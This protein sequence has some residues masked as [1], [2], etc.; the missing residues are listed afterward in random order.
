MGWQNAS[1]FF[2]TLQK[3]ASHGPHRDLRRDDIES[4]RC[5]SLVT[6]FQLEPSVHAACA[7][8]AVGLFFFR[9]A[10]PARQRMS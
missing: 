3:L 6:L 7:N 1:P 5:N 9:L 2:C 4:L 8:I 10:T